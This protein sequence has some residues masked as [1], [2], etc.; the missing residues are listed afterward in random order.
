[1][2]AVSP[3]SMSKPTHTA[4]TGH[5]IAAM[6]SGVT[7]LLIILLLP[8]TVH[9]QYRCVENGKTLYTDK[10]CADSASPNTAPLGMASE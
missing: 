3:H 5:R 9:A 8:V 10:P 1:M 2:P 4:A 6:V 7:L